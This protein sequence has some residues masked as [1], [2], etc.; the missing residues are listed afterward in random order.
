MITNV[1]LSGFFTL[2]WFNSFL[3]VF[4]ELKRFS[5]FIY[6]YIIILALNLGNLSN[7]WNIGLTLLE[8]FLVLTPRRNCNLLDFLLILIMLLLLFLVNYLILMIWWL[9]FILF[10]W[11]ISHLLWVFHHII[12]SCQL[13]TE[14]R[15]ISQEQWIDILSILLWLLTN[16]L[17]WLPIL[18]LILRLS[19]NRRQLYLHW[20]W[21][22]YLFLFWD[23][24]S[25]SFLLDFL[26][27]YTFLHFLSLRLLLDYHVLSHWTIS[28][29]LLTSWVP[30][31]FLLLQNLIPVC[32]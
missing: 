13:T 19:L 6:W 25:Q 30:L 3:F 15:V 24:L 14:S 5:G 4:L 26:S 10:G 31:C 32:D 12:I 7:L 22:L 1:A 11:R 28:W 23:F 18:V 20:I 2:L 29:F 16:N 21:V 17:H 9:L 27:L 8:I